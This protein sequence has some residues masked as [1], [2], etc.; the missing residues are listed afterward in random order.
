MDI[1]HLKPPVITTHPNNAH[2]ISQVIKNNFGRIKLVL[3]H[4]EMV[5]DMRSPEFVSRWIPPPPDRFWSYSHSDQFWAKPL[6]LGR[7][8]ETHQRLFKI[9][10]SDGTCFKNEEGFDMNMMYQDAPI[11]CEGDPFPIFLI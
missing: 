8:I 10:F 1:N 7:T 4:K 6:G 5:Y 2:W 3:H 9:E 11:Y